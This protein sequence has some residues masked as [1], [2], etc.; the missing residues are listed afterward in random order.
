MLAFG[1]VGCVPFL[2]YVDYAPQMPGGQIRTSNCLGKE[3]ERRRV[4]PHKHV[5]LQ[6]RRTSTAIYTLDAAPVLVL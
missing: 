6:Y 3:L 2:T 1:A 5:K 4:I